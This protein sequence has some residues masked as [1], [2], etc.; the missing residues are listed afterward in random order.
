MYLSNM[1]PRRSDVSAPNAISRNLISNPFA[2]GGETTVRT[3]WF[4]GMLVAASA[5]LALTLL[6]INVAF[7]VAG[8]V[9]DI[10]GCGFL[11]GPLLVLFLLYP[12]VSML[13]GMRAAQRLIR[14]FPEASDEVVRVC[15]CAGLAGAAVYFGLGLIGALTRP[16]GG[17]VAL[18]AWPVV[19]LYTTVI[20]VAARHGALSVVETVHKRTLAALNES[21]N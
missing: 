4:R 15:G 13:I 7:E 21:R 2:E 6:V 16:Y 12:L 10:D 20:T 11:A 5:A 1:R 8:S 17:P 14:R 19:A 3:F 9:P 18:S